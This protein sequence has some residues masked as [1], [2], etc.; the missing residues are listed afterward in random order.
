MAAASGNGAFVL[1]ALCGRLLLCLAACLP[2]FGRPGILAFLGAGTAAY[3]SSPAFG[4]VGLWPTVAW[5]ALALLWL[6]YQEHIYIYI[7]LVH[8]ILLTLQSSN[9]CT[10]MRLV[11]FTSN[12][13]FSAISWKIF[14]IIWSDCL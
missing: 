7:E 10:A 9:P 13:N 4:H 1:E 5:Q 2:S 3:R 8:Y 6:S 14:Y 11:I 12:Y